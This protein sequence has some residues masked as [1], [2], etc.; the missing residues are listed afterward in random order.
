MKNLYAASGSHLAEEADT[1][2]VHILD[3]TQSETGLPQYGHCLLCGHGKVETLTT[4]VLSY[5]QFLKDR[6]GGTHG[7]STAIA[8]IIFVCEKHGREDVN[9]WV[10]EKFQ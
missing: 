4:H 1:F 8:F 3:H 6:E 7:L 2:M 9:L 5:P 10:E